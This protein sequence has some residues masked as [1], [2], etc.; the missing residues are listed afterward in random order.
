MMTH[1]VYYSLTGE[2][3]SE[4]PSIAEAFKHNAELGGPLK[5][6]VVDRIKWAPPKETPKI[7]NPAEES[8]ISISD[9]PSRT[10]PEAPSAPKPADED[11][12]G[13]FD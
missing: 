2:V 11:G 7:A 12:P 1:A 13:L 5:G 9:I 10:K 6:Y 4:H 3:I 8:R